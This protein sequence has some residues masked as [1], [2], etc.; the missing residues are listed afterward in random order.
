M[1]KQYYSVVFVFDI[2]GQQFKWLATCLAK[3]DKDLA[4]YLSS[5]NATFL[6]QIKQNLM[7]LNYCLFAAI[8]IFYMKI[9]STWL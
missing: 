7:Q 2:P 5:L 9:L 6:F 1:L 4:I 3:Q 8:N